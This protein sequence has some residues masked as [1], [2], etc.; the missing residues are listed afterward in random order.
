[1]S[2]FGFEI[3]FFYSMEYDHYSIGI[4]RS[5][6]SPLC[7]LSLVVVME[8]NAPIEVPLVGTITGPPVITFAA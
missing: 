4:S 2:D 3:H 7:G 1:V 5:S 6:K 8:V